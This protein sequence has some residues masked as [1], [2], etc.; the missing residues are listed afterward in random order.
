MTFK[1]VVFVLFQ[2]YMGDF[3]NKYN[4]QD[5]HHRLN[6]NTSF[7]EKFWNKIVDDNLSFHFFFT[8]KLWILTPT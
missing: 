7:S 4:A 8:N 5:R 3:G 2:N 6:P 1:N